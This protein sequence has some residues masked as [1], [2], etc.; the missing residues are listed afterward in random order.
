MV[1]CS[2]GMGF[3]LNLVEGFSFEYIEHDQFQVSWLELLLKYI[4]G[5]IWS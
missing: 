2:L 4:L 3:E 1:N 5:V